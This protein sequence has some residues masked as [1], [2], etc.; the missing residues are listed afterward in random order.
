QPMANGQ[1]TLQLDPVL[2]PE[3]HE[4]RRAHPS[5][6]GRATRHSEPSQL[7]L[8]GRSPTWG[9][10]EPYFVRP[11][12]PSRTRSA[13]AGFHESSSF[14]SIS[15]STTRELFHPPPPPHARERRCAG[16]P[17]VHASGLHSE[18]KSEA[19]TS[20]SSPGLART[21]VCGRATCM[22]RT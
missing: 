22:R 14:T 6:E 8:L 19:R 2:R 5:A 7:R 3:N 21:R 20:P 13:G 18:R 4:S 12:V 9:L 16:E 15:A 10:L 17:S 11:V 1:P